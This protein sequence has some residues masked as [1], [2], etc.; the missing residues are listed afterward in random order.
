MDD[1]S[2]YK[3]QQPINVDEIVHDA[4]MADEITLWFVRVDGEPIGVRM[5]GDDAKDL[6]RRLDDL[7]D[8]LQ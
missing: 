2:M 4:V 5:G 1:A 7:I 6:R 3:G 8:N